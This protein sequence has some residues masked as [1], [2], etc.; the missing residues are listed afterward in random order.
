MN[1]DKHQLRTFYKEL[2]AALSDEELEEKSL[3]VSSNVITFLKD[4]NELRNFHLFF[5]ISKQREINTYPIKDYLDTRES[6]IY[7]SRVIDDSLE[8][9]TLLLRSNTRFKK[10]K[11]GIP[12]PL[13]FEV[14]G[15]E[16]IEV[17]FVPLLAFDHRGNRVGFG[18]GYYDVLLTGLKPSVL[19]IGLSIFPPELRIPAEIHDIPLDYCITPENIITF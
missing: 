10:D 2:R 16:S 18:K 15:S 7:T 4:K 9:Q 17:V 19:K 5:P 11:W 14:V 3:L 8:L 6:F 1:L 13:E 12:I